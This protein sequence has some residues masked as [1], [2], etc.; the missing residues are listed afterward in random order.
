MELDIQQLRCGQCGE[1]KHVLYLRPNGEIITECITCK[2]Q[3]EI[4]ITK[5][6]IE[7]RNNE[8]MGRL[9]V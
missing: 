7:I 4:V 9:C 2:S 3:S 1:L 8:G 5:P 6:K